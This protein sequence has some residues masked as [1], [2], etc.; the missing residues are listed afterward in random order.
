[1]P[2]GRTD[3]DDPSRNHRRQPSTDAREAKGGA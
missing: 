1:V 3:E 2:H